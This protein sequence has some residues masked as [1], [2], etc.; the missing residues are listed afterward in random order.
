MRSAAFGRDDKGLVV[1][2]LEVAVA[3]FAVNQFLD[4]LRR[5]APLRAFGFGRHFGKW[6]CFGGHQHGER[7]P[8]PVR[9]PCHCARRF[10]HAG[11][12]G[13]L[14]A[15][16]PAHVDLRLPAAVREKRDAL[17]VGRPARRRVAVVPLCDRTVVLAVRGDDPHVAARDVFHLVGEL[18]YIKDARAIRRQARIGHAVPIEQ[19]VDRQAALRGGRQ[20]RPERDGDGKSADEPED[21]LHDKKLLFS[22]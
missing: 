10:L 22:I 12:F 21:S 11:H 5:F 8:F 16:H 13:D 2:V 6:F 9:R 15:V 17:A 19:R 3:I 7:D 1:A 4:H 20:S 14:A 18:I